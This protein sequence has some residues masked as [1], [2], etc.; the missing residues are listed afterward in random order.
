LVWIEVQA[1]FPGARRTADE[2]LRWRQSHVGGLG[3][4]L[5]G[6]F[7]IDAFGLGVGGHHHIPDRCT[8]HHL[9]GE[10]VSG[11]PDFLDFGVRVAVDL[12]EVLALTVKKLADLF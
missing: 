5:P 9:V 2:S 12:V 7:R 8:Y 11:G 10:P 6:S 4:D 1:G 3:G